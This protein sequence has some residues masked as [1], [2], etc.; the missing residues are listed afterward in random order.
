M[1]KHFLKLLVTFFFALSYRQ[2]GKA[3][4][5]CSTIEERAPEIQKKYVGK[6]EYVQTLVV[7]TCL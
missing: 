1:L 3:K 5:Y 6:K 4:V 7:C 2:I